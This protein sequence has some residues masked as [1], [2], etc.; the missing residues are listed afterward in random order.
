MCMW[1]ITIMYTWMSFIQSRISPFVSGSLVIGNSEPRCQ[2]RWTSSPLPTTL[3]RQPSILICEVRGKSSDQKKKMIERLLGL[4][5]G[6]CTFFNYVALSYGCH[7]AEGGR[8]TSTCAVWSGVCLSGDPARGTHRVVIASCFLG[9][10]TMTK[11]GSD[12][13][14]KWYFLGQLFAGCVHCNY[15]T[16]EVHMMPCMY[17]SLLLCRGK[18]MLREDTFRLSKVQ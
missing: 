4:P 3:L 2:V 17:V 7:H 12:T 16:Y 11:R 18:N 10:T 5:G 8:F 15:C 14:E 1:W 6:A 9:Q 13:I